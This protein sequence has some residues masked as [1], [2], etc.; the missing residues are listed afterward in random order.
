MQNVP[1]Q[2]TWQLPAKDIKLGGR[3]SSPCVN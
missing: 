2:F 1:N 3:A